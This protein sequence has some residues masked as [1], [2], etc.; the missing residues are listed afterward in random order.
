MSNQ[1][2]RIGY[3]RVNSNW[4]NDNWYAL[5]ANPAI[6]VSLIEQFWQT[7]TV[8]T[9]YEGEQQLTVTVDGQTFAITKASI[10]RHLQLADVDGI[11]SLPN[12]KIF[13]Q[14]SLMGRSDYWKTI[15]S[16]PKKGERKKEKMVI[17]D[18]EEELD[19]DDIFKQGMMKETKFVDLMFTKFTPTKATQG[20]EKS[21][22][23]SDAH[24]GVLS[25]AKILADASREREKTYTRR[26][27]STNSSRE[28]HDEEKARA[29]ARE[30]QEKIDFEKALKLQ[31][32]LDEREDTD[33]I[34][35]NAIVEQVQQRESDTVKRYQTLKKKPVFV[36]QARKN[37]MTYLK[38]MDGYK[39][40]FFKGMSY[41]EIRPIFEVEYNKL[42]TLFK[43]DTEV[44]KTKIKRV[45]EETL[46]QES[47]KKL[48][49][50][51][52]SRSEPVQEQQ[53]QELSE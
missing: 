24:L 40:H 34:D 4:A 2:Q 15:S 41:D 3:S 5:T 10:R 29:A 51:E 22:D 39:M 17:S 30:E 37:M 12:T 11:S 50:D 25:A 27:R 6:Y 20:E 31:R 1:Q 18:D 19:I 53:S 48:R 9:V 47:F 43:K 32:Q 46:H 52:A 36:A 13:D 45:A 8:E 35:W 38:N 14:F 28:L 7:V 44:E 42:Q 49:E 16:L 33:D 21:Q 23:S 26:R